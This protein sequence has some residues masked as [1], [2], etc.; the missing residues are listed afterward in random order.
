MVDRF[1]EELRQQL[2]PLL[3]EL[4]AQEAAR[5][6]LEAQPHAQFEREIGVAG[7]IVENAFL[8]A[9]ES[10]QS[11]LPGTSVSRHGS[12]DEGTFDFCCH[13]TLPKGGAIELHV[14]KQHGATRGELVLWSVLKLDSER[15]RSQS[16]TVTLEV[17][18]DESVLA[19]AQAEVLESA[20]EY[21]Q[22]QIRS[23]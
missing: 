9:L 23:L 2:Q 7:D 14:A 6:G 8:P 19:W 1:L 3:R 20:K 21:L 5:D 10:L 12:R 18:R 4:D 13:C 17:A 11:V 15:A 22:S 16:R